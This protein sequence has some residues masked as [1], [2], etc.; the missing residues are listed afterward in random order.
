MT[1]PLDPNLLRPCLDGFPNDARTLPAEAYTSSEVFDWEQ[2]HFLEGS[3]FCAGRSSMVAEPG[4]QVALK[5]GWESVLLTR[6]M[7]GELHAFSNVC[8]HRGHE[9]LECPGSSRAKTI[10]CPYHRWT[11]DLDGTFKG[12][13]GVAS[14][15]GFDKR[16]PGHSL[17]SLRVREWA[18]WIFLN[19]AGDAPSLES[20][21]GSLTSL[22]L[23]YEPDRLFVAASHSYDIAANWKIIAEN[24]HECYHCS[25]I[26]PELCR[27]TTP[28]SGLDY[29]PSGLV[30]G[31]SMDLLPHAATMSLDG[32]S[33]GVP[34]RRLPAESLRDVYYLQVFP[35]L[36]LSLHP[37]YVMTH[38]IEP[39]APGLSRIE[40]SW[41]FPFEAKEH[42][43][44][45]PSYA[46]EFW[47]ITNRE[48]W[49]ACEAVQRGAGRRGYRQ[50]PFSN[51]E[52]IVHQEMALVA[53]AYLEGRAPQP[54]AA[55]HDLSGPAWRHHVATE[56]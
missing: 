37:D 55:E 25:E 40:C 50:S 30:I 53:R 22:I 47:D 24:Y 29:E 52:L 14:Q 1:A 49:A 42:A 46:V 19:V 21:V 6:S 41:L 5:V 17:L 35:N 38:V 51:Q 20:H 3:W 7:G 11:Y 27:V 10:R 23:G 8:R 9:L 12:G 54:A 2:K 4:E 39:L 31:G 32:S 44:F 16:D 15:Q 26:H 28:G 34:F 18:G 56:A 33:L 48:D 43:G 36:L 45:D 13:P